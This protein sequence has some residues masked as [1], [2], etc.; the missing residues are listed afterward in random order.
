MAEAIHHINSGSSSHLSFE[1][2]YRHSYNLV[3]NKHGELLYSGVSDT[4]AAHLAVERAKVSAQPD[5]LLLPALRAA[6]EQHTVHMRMIRDILMYMDRTHVVQQRKLPIYEQ[7]LSLFRSGVVQHADVAPRVQRLLLAAVRSHRSGAALDVALMRS[8]LSMLVDL[9]GGAG[10]GS[11]SAAGGASGVYGTLFEAPLLA[12]SGQFFHDE[13]REVLAR[14]TCPEYCAYAERRLAEERAR[15]DAVMHGLTTGRLLSLVECK[16]VAEHALALI[17]AEGSGLAYQ[18]EHDRYE[19]MGR[20]YRLTA[21]SRTFV[22]WRPPAELVNS[23]RDRERTALPVTVLKDSFK[24]LVMRKGLALLFDAEAAKDP[25]K[26]IAS[27]LDARDKYGRAVEAGFNGDRAFQ[28][29]LKEA[30]E[31]VV[32]RQEEGR[33]AASGPNLIPEALASYVDELLKGEARSLGEAELEEKLTRCVALFRTLSAKDVF[34]EYYKVATARR[35]LGG[36]VASEDVERLMIGKLKAECGANYTNKLEGMFADLHKS[37]AFMATFRRERRERLTAVAGPMDLDVT[38]LTAP[39]WSAAVRPLPMA[40][41]PPQLEAAIGEFQAFYLDKHSGRKLAWNCGKGTAEIRARFGL[42]GGS[43]PL[44]TYELTVSTY[45]MLILL[46]IAE[47]EAKAHASGAASSAACSSGGTG[48]AASPAVGLAV[49][50]LAALEIPADELQRNLLSLCNPKMRLLTRIATAAASGGAGAGAGAGA[51]STGSS[52]A[53][54]PAARREMEAGD[55]FAINDAFT[56]KLLRIKVPLISLKSAQAAAAASVARSGSTGSTSSAA[57]GAGGAG[58]DAE[59][60]A[61][62]EEGRKALLESVIVRI[63][64][65]RKHMEHN[66]LMAEVVRMVSSRFAPDVPSIKRRIE[67]LI[68]RDYLERSPDNHN[69]YSYLS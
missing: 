17:D 39:N 50:D 3:L 64:K 20:L 1:E 34:E 55:V 5:E 52:A 66:A 7:G 45:Q 27:L 49:R 65:T 13:S 21:A 31:N 54:A 2:L 36:R 19:D 40:R 32:N 44:R 68:E 22:S 57:G 28:L 59:T 63:M 15:A 69:M 51:G 30:F 33:P 10:A 48:V 23:E 47:A 18:L 67:H 14:S 37:A 35:L 38:V 42:H 26:L 41:M 58:D 4:I 25:V 11:G 8:V 46:A 24:A 61:A 56:S 6:Y 62:V 29:A 16:L 43:G 9:A 12:E 53:P 60:L